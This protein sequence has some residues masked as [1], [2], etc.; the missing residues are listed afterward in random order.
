MNWCTGSSNSYSPQYQSIEQRQ[1]CPAPSFSLEFVRFSSCCLRVGLLASLHL[2]A[3]R[4]DKQRTSKSLNGVWPSAPS[5]LVHSSN[6]LG[7]QIH[8]RRSLCTHQCFNFC[9]SHP[10]A[11]P[12]NHL[13]LET[14]GTRHSQVSLNLRK[15]RDDFEQAYKHFQWL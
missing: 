5:P 7:L 2:G 1:K 13:A 3:N 9:S 12:L 8:P 11:W 14:E 4:T 10:R 6:K 15:Q